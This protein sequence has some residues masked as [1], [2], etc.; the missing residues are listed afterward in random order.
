MSKSESKS[1]LPDSESLQQKKMESGPQDTTLTDVNRQP[2]PGVVAASTRTIPLRLTKGRQRATML[3]HASTAVILILLG[4][5]G[6]LNGEGAHLLVSIIDI[7]IGSMVLVFMRRELDHEGGHGGI[8]WV[9]ILAGVMILWE[10]WHKYNPAKGFQPATLVLIIGVITI[11]LGVFHG[12][13][14]KT[15]RL[16]LEPDGFLIRTSP[17]RRLRLRWKE[18]TGIVVSDSLLTAVMKTGGK[19]TISLKSI[20]NHEELRKAIEEYAPGISSLPPA[21]RR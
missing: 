18:I 15:R 7:V 5:E 3:G 11:A 8:R 14:P 4:V 10:A 12:R 16:V 2:P 9:D 17:F 1:A 21:P 19:R 6:L 13:I 20:V